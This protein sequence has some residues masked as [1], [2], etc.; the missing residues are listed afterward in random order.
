MHISED[1]FNRYLNSFK[2]LI[3]QRGET[4]I[5]YWKNKIEEIKGYSREKAIDEL[6][7]SLKLNAKIVAISK[8]TESLRG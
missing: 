8:F 4:E 2:S 7:I 1:A 3:I 6:L 5:E